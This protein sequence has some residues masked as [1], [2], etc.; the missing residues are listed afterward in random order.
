LQHKA[1]R[2]DIKLNIN[3]VNDKDKLQLG[4]FS[5]EFISVSH[6]IPD[7]FTLRLRCGAFSAVH[8]SDF[9]ID[10]DI[11]RLVERF[12][13]PTY[14]LIDSTNANNHKPPTK[15]NEADVYN[16]LVAIFREATGRVFLTTFASN[17]ERLSGAI[18][19]AKATGRK[20]VIE[21]AAMERTIG[22]ASRLGLVELSEGELLS[23]NNARKAEA[24]TLLYLVSGC[25]GEYTS[26]LYTIAMDERRAI[27]MLAGDT[28][29]FSSRTIPGNERAVNAMVNCAMRRGVEVIQ[30]QDRLVHISGH[31]GAVE[32]TELVAGVKPKWFIP[33]HG[34]YQHLC[35][36]HQNAQ[37]AGV[38]KRN[39]LFLES[40]TQLVFEGA[41][42]KEQCA[43]QHGRTYVDGKGELLLDEHGLALRRQMANNGVVVAFIH[44]Q[45]VSLRTYGFELAEAHRCAIMELMRTE[46]SEL[47][48]ETIT[49]VLKRYFR[50]NMARRPYVD[51]V[52]IDD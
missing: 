14:L 39:C 43:I 50:K 37:A 6:S 51:T 9:R 30:A 5:V 21:G 35:A 22:I 20:I 24:R 26:A 23:A 15:A 32:L 49:K 41:E 3:I 7:T 42:L 29:I 8:A 27:K 40:G 1:E 31:L 25:Q 4:D 36:N 45:T 10:G 38:A 12:A 28:L 16:E 52:Q 2:A 11:P 44:A 34:E 46:A 19:A 13:E 47:T 18:R 48:P 17:V 33:I